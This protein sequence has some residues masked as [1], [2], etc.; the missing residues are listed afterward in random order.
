MTTVLGFLLYYIKQ[1][2]FS[3]TPGT[4]QKLQFFKHNKQNP[5]SLLPKWHFHLSANSGVMWSVLARVYLFLKTEPGLEVGSINHRIEVYRSLTQV[6]RVVL[7]LHGAI[8]SAH[9]IYLL[10]RWWRRLSF[11]FNDQN[12]MASS[13]TVDG[14]RTSELLLNTS[15]LMY[16][17]YWTGTGYCYEDGGRGYKNIK[18]CS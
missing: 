11:V 4:M 14:Y 2:Y 6:Y 3:E 7:F 9:P 1:R 5:R 10:G 13:K 18:G 17:N 12:H 8:F 16:G 15:S